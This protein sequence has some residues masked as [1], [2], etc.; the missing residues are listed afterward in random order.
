[1]F[2]KGDAWSRLRWSTASL[3]A[4]LLAVTLLATVPVTLLAAWLIS[5]QAVESKE[6]L[7]A[8]MARAV[9]AFALTVDRELTSSAEALQVLALTDQLQ[10]GDLAGVFTSMAALPSPRQSW[11]S[12]FLAELDGHIVFNTQQPAGQPLGRFNDAAALKRLTQTGQPVVTNLTTG[13]DVAPRQG[14]SYPY[15]CRVGW[16]MRSGPGFPRRAG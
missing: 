5:Q 1:V 7:D 6:Q 8:D 15:G 2:Y 10:Q 11:S 13:P 9:R 3:R 16:P 12:V 14:C 4:H